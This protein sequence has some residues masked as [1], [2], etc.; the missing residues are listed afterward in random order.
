M[1]TKTI[2]IFL[3][4]FFISLFC[5]DNRI[6]SP[7]PEN[8]QQSLFEKQKNPPHHY[9][10][11][12]SS[13]AYEF[14]RRIIL[15]DRIKNGIEYHNIFDGKEAVVSYSVFYTDVTLDSMSYK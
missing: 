7:I 2:P 11:F 14:K 4:F 8:R 15:S 10:A 13:I 5:I 1:R 6:L 9:S 12:L 3:I